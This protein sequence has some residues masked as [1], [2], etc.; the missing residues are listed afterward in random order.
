M[1]LSIVEIYSSG[2]KG[3]VEV[4]PSK[5][6]LHRAIIC[7]ALS[8]KLS[9][10]YPI[11]YSE[12]ILATINAMRSL[13]ADIETFENSIVINSFI[14]VNK[15]V[16]I[17]CFDSGSTLRFLIPLV[18]ALGI[19]TT[20]LLGKSLA[21]RP[22]LPYLESLSNHGLKFEFNGDFELIISGKLT[23]GEFFVPGRISSQFI[24]GLMMALPILK[25]DSK[26]FL[27]S[28]LESRN[29]AEMTIHVME[30]FC[31][32]VDKINKGYHISC[33]QKYDSCDFFVEG[34]WSQA[35]FFLVGGAIAGNIIL[36]NL[37]N[38]SIQGDK[39]IFEILLRMGANISYSKNS[40]IISSGNLKGIDIDAKDIPDLVPIICVAAAYADGITKIYNVKRLKFKECNRLSAISEELKKFGVDIEASDECIIIRGKK[41]LESNSVWSHNDHRILMSLA[42]MATGL[43]GI[44]KII[45]IGCVKKS[46]PN[47]FES[48]KQLGGSA[49]VINVGE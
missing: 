19:Q 17:N 33:S 21:K 12:D 20:F 3:E 18:A 1:F 7:G 15:S 10:I 29:Y 43:P 49:N 6:Y 4:P 23:P 28:D 40:V 41:Y 8:G 46:Y 24:S 11:I 9:K 35:A 31:I 44:T 25:G 5:S 30:K 38:N 39:A 14:P 36:K 48:F 42:I 32:K 47:F 2:L 34:D 45:D 16:K 13:G 22:I 26:I 37:E 27:T